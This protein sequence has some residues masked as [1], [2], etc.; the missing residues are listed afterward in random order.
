MLESLSVY[1]KDKAAFHRVVIDR[2]AG[3]AAWLSLFLVRAWQISV[4]VKGRAQAGLGNH[5]IGYKLT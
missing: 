5:D 2:V 1:R 3:R 4:S